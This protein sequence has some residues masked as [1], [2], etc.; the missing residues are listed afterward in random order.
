MIE[1]T[2]RDRLKLLGGASAL[3]LSACGGGNSSTS[4]E[5]LSLPLNSAPAPTVPT[6]PTPTPL[7][8]S[9]TGDGMLVDGFLR[10]SFSNNFKIGTAITA[11]RITENDL[12]A[13]IAKAQFN[14]ITPEYEL[15]ADQ[16]APVEGVFN[17][18][19]A[20]RIVDWA[21]ANNMEVRGHAL[22]W[23]EATP[24]YFY[25][26]TPAQIRARL[27]NYITTVVNHFKDRIKIWDV[28]N[29]VTSVDIFN[30]D[31]GVGPYRDTP[32]FNA[33]GSDYIE[34]AF[35]AARAAD[36]EAQLFLSDYETENPIKRA[37]TIE[38]VRNLISKGVPI[39]GVGHQFHL[40]LNT[41][42]AQTL[43]AITAVDNEF[44]GLINHVTELDVSCYQD[45]GSCWENGTNCDADL[46]STPP[47][48]LLADQ[49][50]L[51]RTIFDGLALKSSVETVSLWGVRD[52][53]SWLNE[54][55]TT[56]F[57]YPLLFDRNGDVKPA[58]EAI[59]DPNY[60]I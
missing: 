16:I 54:S 50:R 27:E 45:P 35:N 10:D 39:N 34:W 17:F 6:A 29:E 44:A 42:P 49:A 22:V 47:A 20:D 8:P 19:E 57:N 59:T 5:I 58:L 26:G 14:S 23:H 38:I 2:A 46:G 41:D 53:D 15:K 25:E 13:Q 51:L 43:A 24:A 37:W 1:F 28:V 3:L 31:D 60:V 48:A 9:P 32:W 36:P 33:V 55:P 56:R 52:G 18:V 11:N 30:G 7:P 12:S 4:N 40:Q 21:I